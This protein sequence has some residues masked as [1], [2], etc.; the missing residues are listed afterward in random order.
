M[1]AP[2]SPRSAR[3][4]VS[5]EKPKAPTHVKFYKFEEIKAQLHIQSHKDKLRQ[6]LHNKLKEQEQHDVDQ[7][8]LSYVIDPELLQN[9]S[10]IEE[11]CLLTS[12]QTV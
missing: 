1:Q 7:I 10:K 8:N 5:I 12:S 4:Q 2:C 11:Q 3:R 6:R 9:L